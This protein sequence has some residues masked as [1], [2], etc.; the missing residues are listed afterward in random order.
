MGRGEDAIESYCVFVESMR[1]VLGKSC[2]AFL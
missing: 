1:S 2:F